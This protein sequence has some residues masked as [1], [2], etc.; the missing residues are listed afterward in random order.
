MNF[1]DLE[2]LV[3]VARFAH[4]GKA[5]E[6]CHV[7]QSTLSVQLQKLEGEVGAQ[8][9]ER[10]SRSVVVTEAGKEAVRRARELLQQKREL[11]DASGH[12]GRGLPEVARVGAIPTI[13]P[14]LLVPLQRG[15]RRAH[16]DTRLRFNEMVTQDLTAA[17]VRGE[18]EV[19]IVATPVMDTLLDEIELFEEPFLL[20]V[21]AR[22]SL[23]KSGHVRPD[24]LNGSLLLL[25][26]DTHCLR[27]QVVGF[28]SEQGITGQRQTVACSIE[29]LLAFVRANEGITLVPEMAMA[30]IK[31]MSGIRYRPIKPPPSRKVRVVFRKTSHLGRRLA[32]AIADVNRS[33]L[34][35]DLPG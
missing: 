32:T 30:T 10:T 4:F 25:L 31:R 1:R 18:L 22:H 11:I 24:E 5:A 19:G 28:C 3:A 14:Y 23:A 8:L 29:T 15:F 13:A 9:L 17:V 35:D 7:S 2:Y 21:P 33:M 16:P 12:F 6:H 26:K 34:N 27:E 20:A